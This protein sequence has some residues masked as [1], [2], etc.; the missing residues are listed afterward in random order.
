MFKRAFSTSL[1]R[2]KVHTLQDANAFDKTVLDS[3]AP[4]TLVDFTA[5]W[6]PPCKLLNPIL[7]KVGSGDAVDVVKVDIDELP[8]LAAQFSV[9]A[10][11]TVVAFKKGNQVGQFVGVK[12]E[13]DLQAWIK[14]LQDAK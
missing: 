6:C 7:T 12:S 11:P 13:P 1:R 10:V 8:D 3:I 4:V 9:S 14:N 2:L 5:T